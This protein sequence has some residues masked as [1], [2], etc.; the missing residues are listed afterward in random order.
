MAQSNAR[1]TKVPAA[2]LAAKVANSS[3]GNSKAS[4]GSELVGKLDAWRSNQDLKF[5]HP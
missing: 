4:V 2:E 1:P 3:F 5:R